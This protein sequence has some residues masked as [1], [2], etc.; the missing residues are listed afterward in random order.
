MGGAE[1][2][3]KVQEGNAALHGGQVRQ[4]GQIHDLLDASGGEHGH[5]GSAAVHHV[6][7]VTENGVGVGAY[8]AG[9]HVKNAGMAVA[10]DDMQA[11]DHQH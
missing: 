9:G 10:G 4:G 8:G 5:A 1:A 6:L 3:E 7:M 2:V 11:G